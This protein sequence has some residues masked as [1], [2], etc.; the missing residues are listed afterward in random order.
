M[1][2][3]DMISFGS[4]FLELVFGHVPALPEPGQEIFAS[5]FAISCGGAVTSATAAAG[6]G[7][8]AGV[9]TRLGDD[10]GARVVAEHCERAGLDLSPSV[11][12]ARRATGITMVLN[13]DGDRSFVTHIPL[14]PATEQPELARWTDV[15]R[16]RRPAWCYV[17][18]GPGVRQFLHAAREQGSKILLD[19][20]HNAI[21][22]A[23]ADV[24]D[25]IPLADV[26][27]PNKAE[28]LHLTGAG[29]VEA[30][31]AA[32]G[33]TTPTVIKMGADGA[34]VTGPDGVAHVADG[35]AAVEVADL[36][37]AGDS[38]AGA[39]IGHLLRGAPLI[40]AVAAAN[41]AGSAAASRLGAVGPV[42][43]E[44]LSTVV[45]PV[46]QVLEAR[47]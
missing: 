7:A 33:W 18:A 31:V 15:V 22:Q 9:C 24:L 39:L 41:A 46:T 3:M 26:F 8:R 35:V 37:G 36:T 19:V 25:C 6:A 12:V 4:V 21:D 1:A 42:Q 34:L 43:V 32:S 29:S 38:F 45:P 10:L 28:L 14:A 27:T 2:A 23:P 11:R 20:S 5:D 40:R 16:S 17:H 44:G 47:R 30:A 13:Y